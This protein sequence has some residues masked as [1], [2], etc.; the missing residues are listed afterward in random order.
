MNNETRQQVP[1]VRIV[2]VKAGAAPHSNAWMENLRD[3]T[4]PEDST[5]KHLKFSIAENEEVPT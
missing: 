1:G 3:E 5:L 4:T 2:I